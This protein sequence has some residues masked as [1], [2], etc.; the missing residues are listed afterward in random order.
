M[1][2]VVSSTIEDRF[3]ALRDE[4]HKD[5]LIRETN[6]KGALQLSLNQLGADLAI[7]VKQD[8]AK[9]I[10]EGGIELKLGP[11][12]SEDIKAAVKQAADEFIWQAATPAMLSQA[13]PEPELEVEVDQTGYGAYIPKLDPLFY[14]DPF[15]TKVA[16]SCITPAKNAYFVGDKGCGK[17]MLIEQVHAKLGKGVIRFN[18]SGDTTKTDLLGGIRV[19]EGATVYHYGPLPTAM[20]L[21]LTLQADEIDYCPPHIM[22]VMNSVAEKGGKLFLPDTGEIIKPAHGFCIMATANTGGKGDT[23]G[24]YT[25]T[26]VLNSAALDRYAA[27]VKCKYL[28]EAEE[29]AMLKRR[30]P[31]TTSGI[32]VSLGEIDNLW[33]LADLVRQ[34]FARSELGETFSTRKLIDFLDWRTNGFDEWQSLELTLLN[35]LDD[36]DMG[37]VMQFTDRIGWPMLPKEA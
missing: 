32:T 16:R 17:S 15:P 8:I 37:V 10:Q 25:G 33:H 36:D 27:M 14:F 35:H 34:A 30:F 19:V 5:L 11:K 6:I 21:G 18:F 22:A 28:P 2:Q 4:I 26:E 31:I 12:I 13:N 1:V 20:K 7:Q 9:T 24:V 29:K 23:R 3:K